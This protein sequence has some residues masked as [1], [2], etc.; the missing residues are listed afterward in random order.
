[1][2]FDF[3][4]LTSYSEFDGSIFIDQK[5]AR[6]PLYKFTFSDNLNNNFT[7]DLYF[8][9]FIF[10]LLNINDITFNNPTIFVII[11]DTTS[12][13]LIFGNSSSGKSSSDN[14]SSDNSISDN[15]S[16]DNLS[17]DNSS[18]NN[19]SSDD[20]SSDNS[21]S[22]YVTSGDSISNNSTITIAFSVK[23]K[24]R[25]ILKETLRD[26]LRLDYNLLSI[27]N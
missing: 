2:Y 13:N 20:P 4:V 5:Y 23:D 19:F 15:S 1:M 6:R 24:T 17:P 25:Q 21:I 27:V 10:I 7:I 11:N 16:F 9:N 12:D 3:K 14:P 18:S 22:S 26:V 8:M